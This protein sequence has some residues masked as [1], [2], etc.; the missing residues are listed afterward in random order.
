MDDPLDYNNEEEEEEEKEVEEEV[1][2]EIEIEE[3]DFVACYRRMKLDTEDKEGILLRYLVAMIKNYYKDIVLRNLVHT[4]PYTG[5]QIVWNMLNWHFRNCFGH[6]RIM[7]DV[8]L[9]LY[10]IFR[11]MGM[12]EDLQHI[13][14]EE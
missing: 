6:C 12:L 2:K 13:T 9:R 3:L 5:H 1:E 4:V 8:F 14:V 7:P 11:G 10:T